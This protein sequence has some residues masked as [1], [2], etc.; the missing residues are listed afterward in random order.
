VPFLMQAVKQGLQDVGARSVGEVHGL[1]ESGELTMEV[2][3]NG[4][5]A[6]G[7]VHDMHSYSKQLW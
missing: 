7:N 5:Q 4:A 3:S 1:L 2:R 6:E